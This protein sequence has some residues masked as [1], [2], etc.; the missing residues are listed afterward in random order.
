MKKEPKKH[1]DKLTKMW[2]AHRL[3]G[4]VKNLGIK[5]KKKKKRHFSTEEIP[6]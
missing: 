4:K 5:T 6:L 3:E 2:Y 1:T